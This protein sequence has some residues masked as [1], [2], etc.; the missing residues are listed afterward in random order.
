[1]RG[2][3][4]AVGGLNNRVRSWRGRWAGKCLLSAVLHIIVEVL[5]G[6]VWESAGILLVDLLSNDCV[7]LRDAAMD[8]ALLLAKVLQ[9]RRRGHFG[10][11]G[12]TKSQKRDSHSL[13]HLTRNPALVAYKVQQVSHSPQAT[14]L[15]LLSLFFSLRFRRAGEGGGGQGR[16]SHVREVMWC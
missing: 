13:S 2:E 9:M 15:I 14:S 4:G 8:G 7:S 10:M 3:G 6:I 12:A 1:M 16:E 11:R 5:K